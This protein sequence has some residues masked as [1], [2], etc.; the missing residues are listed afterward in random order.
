MNFDITG[1]VHDKALDTAAFAVGDRCRTLPIPV[2]GSHFTPKP[3][4]SSIPLGNGYQTR[5][6]GIKH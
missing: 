6:G 1:D 3:T 5:L 2:L 4:K